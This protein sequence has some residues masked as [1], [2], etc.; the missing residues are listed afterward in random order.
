MVE[1][2]GDPGFV[3][4]PP[5]RAVLARR[6]ALQIALR[7]ALLLALLA[8]ALGGAILAT[9]LRPA[10]HVVAARAGVPARPTVARPTSTPIPTPAAPAR[11]MLGPD[12]E[13]ATSDGAWLA[14]RA[15]I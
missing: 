4:V 14:S 12:G 8:S 1:I 6:I 7:L 13:R 3:P 2:E 5:R 10:T 11:A 15:A 9:E